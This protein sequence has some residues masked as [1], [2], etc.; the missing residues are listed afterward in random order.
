MD[1]SSFSDHV[2]PFRLENISV[3]GRI[4]RLDAVTTEILQRHAYPTPVSH[5]LGE[6]VALVSMMGSVLKFDGRFVL[7]TK[8]DGPISMLVADYTSEGGVRAYASY[9]ASFFADAAEGQAYEPA[10]DFTRLMGQGYIA[11]SVDQGPDMERY[12]GI[13]PLEGDSLAEVALEYFTRSEQVA[14]HVK[15][16]VGTVHRPGDE[17]EWRVGGILMQQ[18]AQS[19]GYDESTISDDDWQRIELLL[20]TASDDEMLDIALAEEELAFRLFHEDGVRCFERRPVYFSC[21]CSLARVEAMLEGLP[22]DQRAPPEGEDHLEVTCGFCNTT[23][24]I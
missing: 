18:T 21:Q 1:A 9:D 6:A 10:K 12:Q 16:S 15:L 23:Y 2:L 4:I 7:Q 14:T 13:V 24:R 20:K 8:S 5:I 3:H 19:G 22:D 17:V 11:F